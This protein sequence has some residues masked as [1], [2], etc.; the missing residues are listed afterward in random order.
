MFDIGAAEVMVIA[1]VAIL[2]I[3]PKDLPRMLKTIGHYVSKLRSMAREF[4]HQF[5]EAARDTGLDDVKQSISS[6]QEFSPSNQAKK[7][8]DKIT[9]EVDDI[10]SEVEKPVEAASPK[11]EAT[12]AKPA[13]KPAAKKTPA[14]KPARKAPTARAKTSAARTKKPAAAKAPAKRKPAAPSKASNDG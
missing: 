6:V 2:V 5:E 10:K 12:P 7:V 14:K 3:G 8:F 9:D 1:V 13:R 11:Q 4:Q